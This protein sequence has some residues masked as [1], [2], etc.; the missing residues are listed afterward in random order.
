VPPHR[1]LLVD[2][3]RTAGGLSTQD[4]LLGFQPFDRKVAKRGTDVVEEGD[5]PILRS[6]DEEMRHR[7]AGGAV[8]VVVGQTMAVQGEM[9]DHM[10]EPGP[11]EG[12][13]RTTHAEYQSGP[14]RPGCGGE[15]CRDAV[16]FHLAD[17]GRL[18]KAARRARANI[19]AAP[20]FP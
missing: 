7:R 18:P 14:H 1:Q 6:L 12:F 3:R 10:G 17:H 8:V 20:G 11:G 19:L 5:H 9:L 15:Q 13:V 4:L 16:D 2:R